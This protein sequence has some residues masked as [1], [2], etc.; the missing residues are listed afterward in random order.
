MGGVLGIPFFLFFVAFSLLYFSLLPL[1]MM[2]LL[3]LVLLLL[4]LMIMLK[5]LLK[6]LQGDRIRTQDSATADRCATS[7]LHTPMV[8]GIPLDVNI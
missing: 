3:L 4:L 7:E 8:L 2:L 1:V 6:Y 5:L